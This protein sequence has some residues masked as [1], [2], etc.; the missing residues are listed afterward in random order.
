MSQSKTTVY[1]QDAATPEHDAPLAIVYRPLKEL[2]PYARNARRHSAKQIGQLRASLARFGWTNAMLIA[3]GVMLA[4]HG[5][6]KAA[7]EMANAGQ[8]VR[9]NP[10][11]W[12]GPTVDLSHLDA[13]ERAAYRITDNRMALNAGWDNALL[14]TEMADLQIKGFDLGLT[15]FAN[16]EINSLLGNSRGV[17]RQLAGEGLVY[18][19]IVECTGE[20]HQAEMLAD[21]RERGLSCKPLIL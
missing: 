12:A 2:V 3:D 5:R 10:D 16:V 1:T 20:R 13:I 18:Q 9:R 17:T 6:L 11:P 21:F 7:I 14:Q 4:G 8:F 19:V 15:G